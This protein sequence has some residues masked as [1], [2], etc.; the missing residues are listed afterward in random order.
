MI[1][2]VFMGSHRLYHVRMSDGNTVKVTEYNPKTKK[3]Y[4]VG[5]DVFL[6]FDNSDI[7]IIPN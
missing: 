2:S 4:N 5:Y 7:H 6:V 1:L 3:T